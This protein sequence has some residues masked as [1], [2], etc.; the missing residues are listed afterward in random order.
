MLVN[1]NVVYDTAT[2]P[3]AVTGREDTEH[4]KVRA[5]ESEEPEKV[6][7]G[8]VA[9]STV[10]DPAAPHSSTPPPRGILFL[11]VFCR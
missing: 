9:G 2:V 7:L 11:F 8:D 1:L 10:E 4:E 3:A 6:K 5:R